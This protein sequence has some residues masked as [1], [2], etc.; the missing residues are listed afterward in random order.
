M[1][2]FRDLL[3]IGR[4]EAEHIAHAFPDVTRRVGGY[5]IDA[6]VPGGKPVNLATLL[7]GSE[8]TLAVSRQI[9]LKLSPLPKNK[10]L[11]ICHFASFRKAMEAAQH[12]VKLGPVAVEVVDRTLIELARDIAMFSPVMDTYVRGKPDALL[13]VEFAEADQAENL[14]RLERL[15]ELM[16]DLGHPA[17]V[18]KVADAAGQA[19]VWSVRAS[20]LNIMM[21]MKIEGKPVSFIEDCAVPLEHLADYTE[22]LTAVFEKHGTKGTWYAHA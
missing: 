12:I 22:R 8:G 16:G 19:A 14:R 20:G 4:R 1:A 5:L 6:L 11:G 2:L 15:E 3:G 13:L 18:V 7:C 10:A 17:S 9:E 21:S